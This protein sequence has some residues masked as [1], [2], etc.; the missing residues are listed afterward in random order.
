MTTTT[1]TVADLLAIDPSSTCTGYAIWRDGHI[2]EIGRITPGRTR[3]H[4]LDRVEAITGEVAAL[5]VECAPQHAV[6]EVPSGRRGKGSERGATGHL[7]IYGV[8]VGAVLQTLRARP[9]VCLTC[10]DERTWTRGRP[11][12]QRVALAVATSPTYDP[13]QD[14]GA[15]VADA[16]GLGLWWLAHQSVGDT[17][18]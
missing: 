4:Y 5:L 8:A 1:P 13:R 16:I 18:R 14:P 7:A 15:D 12:R 11:Q 9:E 2:A 6:I 10:V 17:S 3:D